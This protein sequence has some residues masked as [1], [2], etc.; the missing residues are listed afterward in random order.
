MSELHLA[1]IAL[2]L[3]GYVILLAIGRAVIEWMEK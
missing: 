1:E 3:F 2:Y